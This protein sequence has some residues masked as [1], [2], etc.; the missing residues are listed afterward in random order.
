MTKDQIIEGLLATGVVAIIRVDRS[1]QLIEASRALIDG[2]VSAIEITMTTP[3]ALKV[4]ADMRRVFGDKVLAGVGSIL[5]VRS[6]EA[7][8]EAGAE[9]VITPVLRPEVIAFCNRIG[10]PVFS[11]SYTPTEAQTAYEL[12]ADFIK[13]FPADGLGP[14]YIQAIRGPLPHLKL[15]PTGG[16]DLNSVGDFIRAGCVAVAAGNTLVGK[17]ILK[18][19]DWIRLTGLASQFVA[20]VAKA[21]SG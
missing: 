5:D 8:V 3:N 4:I 7:A 9:Y 19:K 18:N 6:A 10:K 17:D 11:G 2:G 15:V 16:V 13:I 1:E 21:R 12:G 20:A 14:K